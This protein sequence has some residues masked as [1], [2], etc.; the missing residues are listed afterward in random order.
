MSL[1]VGRVVL[2]LN[3]LL[4]STP[5]ASAFT[6]TSL[7]LEWFGRNGNP[8][9]QTNQE[10]RVASMRQHLQSAGLMTDVLAFEEV[11]DLDLLK[12]ELVGRNYR[13]ISYQRS[14]A[15]HQHVV[16]CA[17]VP[18]QLVRADDESNYE[19]EGVDTN[20]HLRPAVHAILK[21]SD[22]ERL[23]HVIGVHLKAMPEQGALRRTQ[24]RR[25]ADYVR[26]NARDPVIVL[27]DFNTYGNDAGEMQAVFDGADMNEL[28]FDEP[29][30][31]ADG[32]S[33]F[34]PAKFDRA[35]ISSSLNSRIVSREV[36]GPCSSGDRTQI[37]N[38]NRNVSDHCALR[39]EVDE[40]AS[41]GQ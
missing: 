35:W 4:F 40:G 13:C 41:A 2:I 9:A 18:Y 20:G 3:C 7:N 23:A 10:S 32:E 34:S 33:G 39:V 11:V 30:T 16:L 17:K 24:V 8:L 25:I 22:G 36:V 12:N 31:W 28:E 21:S 19:L 26:E 37:R 6:I 5:R 1:S 15:N 27:G 38:Y 29:Y 14:D